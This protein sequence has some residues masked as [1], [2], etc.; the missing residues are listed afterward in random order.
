IPGV[1][2]KIVTDVSDGGHR[3][4]EVLQYSKG[5]VLGCNAAGSWNL[6]ASVLN[7]I[8]EEMVTRV[9]QDE[10]QYFLDLCDNRDRRVRLGPIKSIFDFISP[11]SKSLLIFPGTKWCGAGNISKNY[12][13][14][15]K[16]R[17]TDMCCRDHDHA[18]DSLAPH[19]TKYGITN[20]KKYTM[21]N[22]K[23][24][25]KFFNCLLKV[26]S[27]TSNSVGTTFFDILKTKCF[28]YGY[29]DKCA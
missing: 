13:D 19:E 20:V 3:L 27:R 23:D 22:C 4:V 24:D 6:I 2:R 1:T 9:T 16:A 15:G 10:M 17:R 7:V 21:T 18:I 25:C 12:Y 8:P 28:A 11:T 29:P 26:K 14:L 5:A